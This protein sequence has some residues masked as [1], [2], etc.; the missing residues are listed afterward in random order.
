MNLRKRTAERMLQNIEKRLQA[1]AAEQQSM[2][3][4]VG[5][6]TM[7]KGG[8]VRQKMQGPNG[9]VGWK[10]PQL[11]WQQQY[12]PN[13]P[14]AGF[15][16]QNQSWLNN[17]QGYGMDKYQ[18]DFGLKP[19]GMPTFAPLPQY[20][21]GPSRPT[22]VSDENMAKFN[23]GGNPLQNIG[24]VNQGVS[25]LKMPNFNQTPNELVNLKGMDQGGLRPE[26][27][28]KFGFN[29]A[30]GLLPTAF[31]TIAG[32][33]SGRADKLNPNQYQNPYESQAFGMM[34][35]EFR[36]DPM[37]TDN[38]NAYGNYLR[39]VNQTGNSR[40]ER[41][42]NY[43]AGMNRMNEANT[44]A[45]ALKNNEEADMATRKAMLRNAQGDRRA[46]VNLTVRD[47]NDANKAAARNRR[48]AYFAAAA[49]GGQRYGLTQEQMANQQYSQNA[50]IEAMKRM[51]PY[52]NQW[53]GL[54]KLNR[55]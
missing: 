6:K 1:L 11:N 49:E 22:A 14:G 21:G 16:Q 18:A 40:G 55:G 28:N 8:V 5:G 29:D 32:L 37:L 46:G 34:P 43:G 42:A 33:T 17:I 27:N 26:F 35:S 2:N 19:L 36:I 52:W 4:N 38:R 9:V 10:Q 7:R 47:M 20:G 51:G 39:N 53:L 41:M 54:D 48:M 23:T 44:R 30:L 25:N 24:Y 31:N 15:T 50:M 12:N 13:I 45:W 3:G